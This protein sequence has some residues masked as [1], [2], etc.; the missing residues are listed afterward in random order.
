LNVF[1]KGAGA[2]AIL[3]ALGHEV[4]DV[5]SEEVRWLG[6]PRDHLALATIESEAYVR[7]FAVPASDFEAVGA[8]APCRSRA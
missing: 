8:A 1:T 6:N 3:D 2:E 5:L 7:T 4:A